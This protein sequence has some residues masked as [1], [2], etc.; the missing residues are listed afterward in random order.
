M[1]IN[2]CIQGFVYGDYIQGVSIS[3]SNIN[4]DTQCTY[5]VICGGGT[6]GVL[7]QLFMTNV[8]IDA[9]QPVYIAE[10][11]FTTNFTNCTFSPAQASVNGVTL[12]KAFYFAMVGNL[13]NNYG[14][15]GGTS[16]GV[17]IQGSYGN[18]TITGNVFANQLVGV[19]LGTGTSNVICNNNCYYNTPTKYINNG[20]SPTPGTASP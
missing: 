12:V 6:Q 15:A 18:G 11:L 7:S 19:K 8:Q 13:F 17:S 2:N 1:L 5:G 20:T 9:L 4:G 16:T 10:I 3:D 14:A